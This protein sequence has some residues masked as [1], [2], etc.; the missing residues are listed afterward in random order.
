MACGAYR[1]G[2]FGGV[3]VANTLIGIVQELRAKRT[4]D[5]LAVVNAPKVS[6][7]RD[8]AV[9]PLAVNELVARRRHGPQ[10]RSADRR[11]LDVLT[12]TNLEIDESLLTG[13]SEPVVKQP[14]DEL[15]VGQLRRRRGRAGAGH[16]GRRR[17][18]RGAA[19]RGGAAVHAGAQ[20]AA[21]RRSTASSPL[22]TYVLV[23]T[24]IALFISQLDCVGRHPGRPGVGGR[25]RRG[26]GARGADPARRASRSPSASSASPGG[27]RWCRSSRRS[28]CSPAST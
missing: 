23:P 17:R 8:G 20:R 3:V 15:L 2:L 27:A 22:V 18:V 13:E 24:G 11:R 16:Q 19:G 26:D 7:V 21:R 5:S 14:G 28:R 9:T 1:D 10:R 25:R 4:L 6:A 12:A